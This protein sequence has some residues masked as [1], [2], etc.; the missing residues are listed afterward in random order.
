MDA[1]AT[2]PRLYLSS[3]DIGAK[4]RACQTLSCADNALED[5]TLVD[6]SDARHLGHAIRW[7]QGRRGIRSDAGEDVRERALA[8]ALLL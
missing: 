6:F 2:I 7:R 8:G 3:V 5:G 1:S 4:I